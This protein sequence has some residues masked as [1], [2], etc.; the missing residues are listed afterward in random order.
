MDL[1]RIKAL[2]RIKG[3]YEDGYLEA[4][5]PGIIEA[6]RGYTGQTFIDETTGEDRFPAIIELAVAKWV[7]AY[8]NP[9]GVSSQSM[10]SVS[11][12]FRSDASAIPSEVLSLLDVYLQSIEG[13]TST[14]GKFGFIPMPNP[15]PPYPPEQ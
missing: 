2:A 10:G 9:A 1:A 6:V 11:Q 8:T 4:V 15:A 13:E 7:Q 12:S 5:L 14:R 3:D